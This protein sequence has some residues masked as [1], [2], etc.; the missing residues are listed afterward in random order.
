MFRK[1]AITLILVLGLFQISYADDETDKMNQMTPCVANLTKTF[2][3]RFV[4]IVGHDK[5]FQQEIINKKIPNAMQDF[6]KYLM[7]NFAQ[8]EWRQE[9]EQWYSKLSDIDYKTLILTDCDLMIAETFQPV[10]DKDIAKISRRII[11]NAFAYSFKKGKPT[12][13]K[14][15]K[16]WWI[17]TCR[18]QTLDKMYKFIVNKPENQNIHQQCLVKNLNFDE[19]YMGAVHSEWTRNEVDKLMQSFVNSWTEKERDEFIVNNYNI[20]KIERQPLFTVQQEDRLKFIINQCINYA[21]THYE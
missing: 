12:Y 20:N 21:T 3:Q 15:D 9:F 10:Q 6:E 1:L 7:C 5:N 19:V 14:D 13:T 17:Q 16:F 18:E 11:D 2:A 4:Y 8:N